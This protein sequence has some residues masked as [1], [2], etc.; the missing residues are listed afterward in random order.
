MAIFNDEEQQRIKKAV[1]DAE[2]Y[3]SGEIR[4]C[5]EKNCSE[6]VLDRAA[7]YFHKLDMHKTK[8]RNGVLIYL[9][10]V[11]RKFAIIGDAGINKAVPEGF[12]DDAKDA[13]L[14]HF[15]FGNL[16]EGIITGVAMAGEHL[17]KYF[18]HQQDDKNELPDDIAFMDGE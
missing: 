12:W 7:K 5:L 18:P 1:E 4:V 8:L 10:T 15:K 13:M 9:A 11:D 6:E 2:R 17:Q 16:V 14:A 3:T